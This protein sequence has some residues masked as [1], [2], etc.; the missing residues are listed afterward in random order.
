M[1]TL[2][3]FKDIS[4]A[5]RDYQKETIKEVKE[6]VSL[7]GSDL[8]VRAITSLKNYTA[9]SYI[10]TFNFINID[11][12]FSDAGLTVSVGVPSVGNDK[13]SHF[14]AYLEFGTGLSAAALLASY[15]QEIRELAMKFYVNGKGTIKP[16]PY[17]FNN[18]FVV[19]DNFTKELNAYLKKRK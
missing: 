10:E 5:L 14:A 12:R 3:G 4:K 9:P 6:L 2:R 18:F 1:A 16:H 8:E 19:K 15:P 17:L 7:H 11:K 13:R